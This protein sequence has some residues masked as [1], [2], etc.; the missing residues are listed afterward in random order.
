MVAVEWIVSAKLFRVCQGCI[1][2]LLLFVFIMHSDIYRWQT[3]YWWGIQYG[4]M[5]ATSLLFVDVL[6]ALSEVDPRHVLE[7]FTCE[8]CSSWDGFLLKN[9]GTPPLGERR[10]I[11]PAEEFKYV[12]IF[13]INRKHVCDWQMHPFRELGLPNELL[14]HHGNQVFQSIYIHM[15]TIWWWI[16]GSLTK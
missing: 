16:L 8:C 7:R 6:L 15:V 10:D 12:G 13:M 11:S 1:S 2:S 5:M 4:E 9:C 14:L 3:L